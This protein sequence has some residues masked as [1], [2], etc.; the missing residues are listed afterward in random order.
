M[1]KLWL[2]I[3]FALIIAGCGEKIEPGRSAP[4]IGEKIA[5]NLLTLQPADRAT[6]EAFVGSIESLDRAL[7]VSRSSGIITA[8]S[9]REGDAVSAGQLLITI[10]DDPAIDQLQIA[11]AALTSAEKQQATA[12]ARLTL[13]EQT[14]R[15]YQQLWQKQALTGQEYDQVKA[16]LE[17][18]RQQAA[19]SDSEVQRASAARAAALR[20]S[21]FSQV[22]AP[23]AGRVVSLQA[24][25]GSTV[26]PGAPLL[27]LDRAG[28]RQAR[29]RVPERLRHSLAIG[30]AMQVEVPSLARS[31]AGQVVR[32]QSGSDSQSRSFEVLVALPDSAALAS[33]AF[34]RAQHA[35]AAEQVLLIPATAV[36]IRGQLTG[37]FIERNGI[38]HFRLVRLGR[39]FDE[40]WEVLSGL[41]SGDRIVADQVNRARDG[42][43]VES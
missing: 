2:L 28:D 7:I 41:Q 31:L 37:V 24:K 33:G 29:I 11:S 6:S 21:R 27:A 35:T 32:I 4:Q 3:S 22:V 19:M 1:N 20:Q 16:E 43:R 30:T 15:R 34:V 25:S 5:L 18:A 10:S 8:L 40:H 42:V 13:A 17:V 23:F 26:L 39:Q 14:N 36:S 12:L 38:L 9:V